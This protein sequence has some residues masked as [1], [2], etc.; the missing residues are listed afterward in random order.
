MTFV[1]TWKESRSKS[2]DPDCPKNYTAIFGL[3]F[4]GLRAHATF[5]CQSTTCC[6]DGMVHRSTCGWSETCL[7]PLFT[8]GCWQPSFAT[9]SFGS[10]NVSIRNK[11]KFFDAIVT[12]IVC[13]G[14]GP[15]CI[16]TADMDKFN[17]HFR[18]M[19]R[20]VV[21][22]P[23]GI[24]WHDPWHEIL[25]IW[26]QRVREMVEACHMKTWAETCASQQWKFVCCIMSL[27]GER[28]VRRMLH[29][30]PIG[31]RR[32]GRPAMSW[33][34]KIVQNVEHLVPVRALNRAAL[35]ACEPQTSDFAYTL[36][37]F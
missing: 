31:R 17:I 36:T 5:F 33:K 10:R 22:A 9:P 14:A 25:H 7:A 32:V 3:M 26:R 27:P 28:W 20:C 18:R 13:F 37:C 34:N 35:S 30:E 23:G 6:F 12:P 29:W 1:E 2:H 8:A 24:C 19:I 15:R 11:L 16:R 21:G 4:Q